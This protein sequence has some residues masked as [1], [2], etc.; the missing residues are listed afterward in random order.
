MLTIN[1][2][3]IE[4]QRG[5]SNAAVITDRAR[6]RFSFS[7]TSD[8]RAAA[9]RSASIE[10]NG[11]KKEI[12]DQLNIQY[13]GPALEPFQ[14]YSVRITAQ[15]DAGEQATAERLLQTGRLGLPWA[16]K[17]ISDGSFS[18]ESP[19][20]PPP[21]VFRRRFV[22]E[23]KAVSLRI[24]ATCMGIFDLYLDGRRVNEDYF[25]PGF[26]DYSANLQYVI[27]E[28]GGLDAGEHVFTAVVAAGWA[29]GRST[30]VDDTTKSR[31]KL[32]ADRQALLAE[33]RIEYEGG[34]TEVIGT[35]ERFEVSED[36]PWQFA[37]FYDGEIYNGAFD[38][39]AVVWRPATLETLRF[40]PEISARY[41]CAVRS[42]EVF[43]PLAWSIAPSGELICDFGQN[44][45]GIVSVKLKGRVE[46][47]V[48]FRHAEA[49]QY[50]E[51][52]VQN[53]R[54]A[55]QEIHYICRGGEQEYFPRFTYMG[56]RYVGITGIRQEDLEIE[57]VAIY[58]DLDSAGSFRCS[59]ADLNQLQSNLTWS[60]KDNFV[61]IPTDCP[62]RDERQGWTGDIALFASTAC[63]NFDMSRFLEKWL[64]DLIT[65]QG[66]DGSLP[67]VI[68]S[69]KGITPVMTT[70]CWS[71][72][73]ILVPWALYLADGNRELL[74]RQYPSMK[75]YLKDV[76]RWAAMSE[77]EYGTPNILKHPFQFGDWC[78]PY[79][80]PPDWLAR[81]PWTGTPYYY[82]SCCIVS[83]IASI[84]GY[85]TDSR[86]YEMLAE[87]INED[88]MRVFTDGTG[89]M[90]EEFQTAYV[91]PLCFGM[92][93]EAQR[94]TMV[95]RLWALIEENGV[96]LN[97]GFPSTPYIL[98]ALADNGYVE[99]AYKLLLQDGDPSWIYPIRQGATTVWEQWGSIQP[100][101]SIRESS[102]NHYAYGAVG[103]FFYRRICGLEPVEAGYRKFS[104]K[105]VPGGDLRFAECEHRC[106]FGT[107]RVRWEQQDGKFHLCIA[108]PVNTVCYV[109]LPNGEEKTVGSG[110]YEFEQ[111]A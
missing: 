79:G 88:Y 7:M 53:L 97:T 38:D 32:S 24:A 47:E 12:R 10:V 4:N 78:A 86:D 76:R 33:L 20:S 36:S 58:S 66:E 68:P 85:E 91:L 51:L 105:P 110:E 42:H 106:P 54:S 11:W 52:Y 101:G 83:K 37:D 95:Q 90:N 92:G 30:H 16:G 39:A 109:V 67:F 77:G 3:R 43:H 102:L 8:R 25:A 40:A 26:T 60:G 98:F 44:I 48:V 73:C 107:I 31:S 71:D 81:G 111:L 28:P 23:K 69:R 104:V 62:Q 56:F 22:L 29:V 55:K 46:Q 50:G 100:D 93:T 74:A 72:S 65:E 15:D 1:E 19:A 21:M 75:K 49:L 18:F 84:L 14:T 99:E 94:R 103:D 63:F 70:S 5:S 45:A 13:A 2:I 59:N 96:H 82:N 6:P 27:Y 57:A 35:D 17:W 64:L 61:D 108:V 89:R 87:K 80:A 41:G 34:G 9:L